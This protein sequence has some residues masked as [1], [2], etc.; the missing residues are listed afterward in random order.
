M[1]GAYKTKANKITGIT[2][3]EIGKKAMMHFKIIAARTKRRPYV[4][5]AYFR[6]EKIF[7]ELFWHHLYEKQ[8]VR[9]KAR[10]AKYFLC[11][12]ELIEHSRIAPTVKENPNRHGEM[13][14]RFFG[15]A[16]NGDAFVVQ[17]KEVK[18]TGE[19]WLMSVF[20]KE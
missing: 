10:R 17:I 16:A 15:T 18:R 9:D 6:K 14:Y 11:A 7:L 1:F 2:W 13:L 3:A 12:I 5:S 8:N 19:K 20:P 4:R